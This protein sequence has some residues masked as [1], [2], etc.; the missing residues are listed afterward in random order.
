MA[1]I[2]VFICWCGA[3]IA[4]SVDIDRAVRAADDMEGVVLARDYEYMCSDQGQQLIADA[5]EEHNLER[6]VVAS[7]SPRMHEETFRAVAEEAG[8]N[9]YLVEIANIREHCS[10]VHDESDEATD[11]AISLIKAAVARA[12]L[13]EKLYPDEIG[14]TRRALIIGGGIAGIQAALDIAEAGYKV[15]IVE[16]SPSIGGRMAM[17]EKTFPTLDC[18]ACI[19][20]PKMVEASSHENIELLTY[21]EVED[22]S[23]YIGNF[24]VDVKRRARSV[25]EEDCN[26]CGSCLQK[27][28]VDDIPHEF[29]GGLGTRSAIYTPYP[30]AV[31]G[32]PVID[33]ENCQKFADGSCGI[34]QQIC[35]VDAVEYEQ[36]DK[37]ETREYGAVLVATGYD[38]IDLDDFGEYQ[39]Q[40]SS[41]VVTS[42]EFERL[43]NPSGPTEGKLK[44]LSNGETPEKIVF[45]Q[46]VGS[47][48][49]TERGNSH[50]S[51]V[52]CMYTAKHAM[53][54]K[55]K[56]PDA[57]AY[58]FYIDIRTAGKDFDEFHR[59][60]VEEYGVKY[61]KGQ[62][63]KVFPEGEKLQ[64]RGVD[65]LSGETIE[66]D[67]DMVVLVAGM[68]NNGESGSLTQKLGINTGSSGFYS[69]AHSKLRPVETEVA[70][71]Y[72]A[73][74]CQGPKD[75]PETVAQ[76][77]GA[78]AKIQGLF[79]NDKLA[80]DPVV[81]EVDKSRCSGCFFCA[82]MCPYD[83]I[84]KEDICKDWRGE[85][86]TRTVAEVN[87][88]LCQG[89]GG[90]TASCRSE[91]IDLKGY[92]NEGIAAEVDAICQ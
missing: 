54:V 25:A 35:P 70:G 78:A 11:K 60:A 81:A 42:L 79:S 86:L 80:S 82:E 92:K 57:E 10:W 89:C 16:R 36:K 64:V 53:L 19:L 51:K 71:V 87:E 7:C 73:G 30:Q 91:A 4:D 24:K 41:D 68:I 12:D 63:G 44:R 90:C 62:V 40:N 74:A 50:C 69:E 29:D 27:C 8:L 83:A 3:N 22:V 38:L 14:M 13:G 26:G 48:D 56:Y 32:T 47:R 34:C 85:E 20:T 17:L 67:A 43:I 31:P 75:I 58:V 72:L 39:Y 15:D 18:S 66:I 52:C 9:P 59:R 23:G 88:A 2:G 37:I 45:V 77:S 76:A 49:E 6:V 65:S 84:D 55:E 21:S 46:C 33:R 61:I 1:R 5:I 28:P